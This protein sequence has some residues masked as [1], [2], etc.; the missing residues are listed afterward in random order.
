[1][2]CSGHNP[3]CNGHSEAIIPN[4]NG[5]TFFYLEVAVGRGEMIPF[6]YL[7]QIPGKYSKLSPPA[8]QARTAH[9]I[10]VCTQGI[11][12]FILQKAKI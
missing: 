1:M 6:K 8:A 2:Q 11:L 4:S 9:F 5:M 10:R 12:L 7:S 3:A